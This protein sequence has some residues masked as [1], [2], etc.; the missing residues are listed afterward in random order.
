MWE[1]KKVGGGIFG[2]DL[3]EVPSHPRQQQHFLPLKSPKE[4]SF[5]FNRCQSRKKREKEEEE[6]GEE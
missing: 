2:K 5:S 4:N 1:R 6:E 3:L